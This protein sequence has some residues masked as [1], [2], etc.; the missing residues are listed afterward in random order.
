MRPY[1]NDNYL[2]NSVT[3]EKVGFPH[4][5][6]QESVVSVELSEVKLLPSVKSEST[7]RVEP[8]IYIQQSD[9]ITQIT[10]TTIRSC[11]LSKPQ[12]QGGDNSQDIGIQY[13]DMAMSEETREHAYSNHDVS[14]SINQLNRSTHTGSLYVNLSADSNQ[15]CGSIDDICNSHSPDVTDA[16]HVIQPSSVPAQTSLSPG[17]DDRSAAHDFTIPPWILV[18]LIIYI[19]QR[20]RNIRLFS[21]KNS[22]HKKSQ[23]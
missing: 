17:P 9:C 5:P 6:V 2:D 14:L 12:G 4:P 16:T 20:P 18:K 21:L 11:P 3:I 1:H 19:T 22:V 23:R 10:K 7:V 15:K 8:T 13:Q